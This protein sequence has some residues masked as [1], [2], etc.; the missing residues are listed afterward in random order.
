MALT[1]PI[2]IGKVTAD[3]TSRWKTQLDLAA[4]ISLAH[5]TAAI[6]NDLDVSSQSGGRIV[7]FPRDA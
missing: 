1:P 7:S 2:L 4:S 5:T 6:A 3:D